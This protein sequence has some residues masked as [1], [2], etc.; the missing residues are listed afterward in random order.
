MK[1]KGTKRNYAIKKMICLILTLCLAFLFVNTSVAETR[2][3]PTSYSA[4]NVSHYFNTSSKSNTVYTHAIDV[5][6]YV[7]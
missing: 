3:N 5:P 2:L 6:T 4:S 1:M 7:E